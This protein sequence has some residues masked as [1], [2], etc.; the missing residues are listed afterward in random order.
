L[1]LAKGFTVLQVKPGRGKSIL[2]DALQ[3][4]HAPTV[5]VRDA[6]L[7]HQRGIDSPVGLTAC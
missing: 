3:L 2:I 4:G 6:A 7:R 5:V 1:T